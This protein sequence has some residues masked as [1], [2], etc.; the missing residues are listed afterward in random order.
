MGICGLICS[1]WG[2][3]QYW[4]TLQIG[5]LLAGSQGDGGLNRS[6]WFWLIT[7]GAGTV[8]LL[9]SGISA[10]ARRNRSRG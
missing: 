8:L 3:Y 2:G 9:A 7:F 10:L 6:A 5:V 4:V 1:L